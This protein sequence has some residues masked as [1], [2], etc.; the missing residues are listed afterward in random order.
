MPPRERLADKKD[1][2]ERQPARSS[3]RTYTMQ[4]LREGILIDKNDLDEAITW[5][6]AAYSQI[7]DDLAIAQSVY[8][9]VKDKLKEIE[10][11]ADARLRAAHDA[12]DIKKPTEAALKNLVIQDA[13]FQR[14]NERVN[15]QAAKV[16]E[17]TALKDSYHQRRY[18]VQ[19]LVTL[20]CANYYGDNLANSRQSNAV[21]DAQYVET[22]ERMAAGRDAAR[23]TDRTRRRGDDN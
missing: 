21:R 7:S 1:N 9:E 17:L 2:T 19:E 15:T 10:A 23:T 4:E 11:E 5:Q 22:R 12:P 16:R 6:V 20:W 14:G 13:A 18:M 3:R 8:D